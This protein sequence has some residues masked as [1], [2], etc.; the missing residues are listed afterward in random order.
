MLGIPPPKFG[1]YSVQHLMGVGETGRVFRAEDLETGAPVAIRALRTYLAPEMNRQV[2]D[3]LNLLIDRLPPHP[4]IVTLLATGFEN[5]EPYLVTD[6]APGEPLD[7]ALQH[8]GPGAIG[9]LLPR[10]QAI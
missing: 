9:D 4:A 1:R 3:G 5:E 10:L 7:R 8:F 6:L 2:V